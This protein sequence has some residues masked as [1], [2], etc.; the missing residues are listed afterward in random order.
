MTQR[1]AKQGESPYSLAGPRQGPT[2]GGT[3]VAEGYRELNP[4][5]EKEVEKPTF[6]LGGNLPHTVRGYQRRK[7]KGGKKDAQKQGGGQ[8]GVEGGE[9]GETEVPP[10]IENADQKATRTHSQRQRTDS[11]RQSNG[12]QDRKERFD[13]REGSGGGGNVKMRQERLMDSDGRDLGPIGEE[14]VLNE[15]V[16]E[17]TWDEEEPLDDEDYEEEPEDDGMPEDWSFNSWARFRRRFQDPIGEWLG[18]MVLCF[19]GISANLSIT[20]S[21]QQ[22]GSVQT[23]YWA[24]GF[25]VMLGIYISGGSSGGHLN[26]AITVIL[27]VYRGFPGRRVPVYIVAQILGAFTGALLAFAIY[28]DDILNLDGALIPSS[29]GINMYTQPKAWITPATAFFTEVLATGLL[30]ASIL[31]LGDDSNSPP[32][33]GMHAFI[34]GLLVTTLLMALSWNTGG[35]MNPARDL[36]PRLAAIAVG[37]P[38]SIF[39]AGNAWWIWGAWGATITGALLGAALYDACIFKGGESPINYSPQK[40]AAEGHKAARSAQ[41]ERRRGQMGWLKLLGRRRTAD[42]IGGKLEKGEL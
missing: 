20:T 12:S 21:Q 2:R 38:T 19:V 29:T 13:A 22:A 24:W 23:M 17:E 3:Y 8:Y 16:M 15:E 32:G 14:P 36:G 25:A 37:Y 1:T 39:N 27:S 42:S 35:C 31:A 7:G 11:Q 10:A 9:K 5:F 41:V 30:C 28:R 18:T 40:W 6:S 34:I 26:P 4:Q 33:A